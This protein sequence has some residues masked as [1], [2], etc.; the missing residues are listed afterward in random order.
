VHLGLD[1]IRRHCVDDSLHHLCVVAWMDGCLGCTKTWVRL[2]GYGFVCVV[3]HNVFEYL[4][5]GER[6]VVLVVPGEPETRGLVVC[7]IRD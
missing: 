7:V 3:I 5:V 4:R 2:N 1:A 6:V